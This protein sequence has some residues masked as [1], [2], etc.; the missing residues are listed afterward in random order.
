M[1]KYKTMWVLC[2]L[3]SL[4][5]HS[6]RAYPYNGETA[7]F[8]TIPGT[9]DV[10]HRQNVC[11]R[12]ED[13]YF[14]KVE[15]RHALEGLDLNVILGS[16]DGAY[17]LYDPELGIDKNEP[18]LI[19]VLLD[20]LGRRGGFTWRNSFGV[21]TDPINYNMTWDEMLHWSMDSY[22]LVADWWINS[23][24]RMHDG[25]VFV[26]EFLDSS[27]ILATRDVLQS[28]QERTI[29]HFFNWL[30]PFD[31]SVWMM[32]L[33][34]IFL[35]GFI[36]QILEWYAEER[37][38]RSMWEWWSENAYLS[39]INFTQ[40]YEYQPKTL[41][42]RIFGVSMAVWALVMTATYTANLASLLVDRKFQGPATIEEIVVYQNK[43]CTWE[44]TAS[45]T[46]VRDTYK[47]A[48]RVPK[49]TEPEMYE[50][51]LNGDCQFILTNMASFKKNKAMRE[52]NPRCDM[53]LV[54]DGDKVV[55]VGSGFV[56]SAD[57]GTLCTGF[58]RD[59][60]NLLMRDII[61]DGFLDRIW[62][63]E[64][65]RTQTIDCLTYRPGLDLPND[66][67]DDMDARTR[68]LLKDPY[69]RS[70]Q[71][72]RRGLKA[73]GKGA[74]GGAVAEVAPAVSQTLTIEQMIGT[75]VCHWGLMVIALVVAQA[76]RMYNRY[77]RRKAE[78]AAI[79]L[80]DMGE[81]AAHAIMDTIS[82]V[83]GSVCA[84]S[85]R[86]TSRSRIGKQSSFGTGNMLD[87]SQSEDDK[88]RNM[89][90]DIK[91]EIDTQSEVA[92]Q[93]E[94]ATMRSEMQELRRQ[95]ES[96]VSELQ[97]LRSLIEDLV[98]M[99]TVPV[100]GVNESSATIHVRTQVGREG[101]DE[102]NATVSSILPGEL[103]VNETVHVQ[104]PLEECNP[105]IY[106]KARAC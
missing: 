13:F 48:I 88:I 9:P 104:V 36:Y 76:N 52:Y 25:V 81:E 68:Q 16:Y 106:E 38:D 24:E 30:K 82:H 23:R 42:S 33:I 92:T 94:M 47:K 34:T 70:L 63:D 28:S 93:N 102:S 32:T 20:E 1:G 11:D 3:L 8:T 72:L 19:A 10:S 86:G 79:L 15:L 80:I 6:I 69:I 98:D 37:D 43:I 95:N 58:I 22:D 73:G 67:A 46:Y 71:G 56:V 103:P 75:F 60:L 90:V 65:R 45:D 21:Y 7:L 35:S 39:F 77:L 96:T 99:C 41:A 91:G 85:V 57:S 44:G 64:Y 100:D 87:E 29:S 89:I 54:G 66:D 51:L 62:E 59:V 49:V 55:Q 14:G 5:L 4:G 31:A 2:L 27:Y 12:F 84:L 97:G 50:G 61:E 101:M 83:G 17:F 105:N 18:G 74:A 78:E 26:E 53:R 40:A